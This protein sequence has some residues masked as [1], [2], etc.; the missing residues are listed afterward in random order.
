MM[1]SEPHW[2]SR[3][4]L[5]SG[6]LE[7]HRQEH[8]ARSASVP[9]LGAGPRPLPMWAAGTFFLRDGQVPG[10]VML[11]GEQHAPAPGSARRERRQHLCPMETPVTIKGCCTH[12]VCP[13]WG[14]RRHWQGDTGGPPH[15]RQCCALSFPRHCPCHTNSEP[16]RARSAGWHH[17]VSSPC[18]GVPVALVSPGCCPPSQVP[19]KRRC[20]WAALKAFI[21]GVHRAGGCT[22]RAAEPNTP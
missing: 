15:R 6:K 7:N 14:H 13:W 21:S 19:S 2:E 16:R 8:P 4:W 12:W 17:G 3:S 9:P 10:W 5:Q 22:Q 20:R 1:G 11:S 18:A